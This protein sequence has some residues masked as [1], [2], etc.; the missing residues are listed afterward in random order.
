VSAERIA[1]IG[2]T[3]DLGYGLALRWAGAGVPVIIGSRDATRATDAAGR[4]N[5]ALAGAPPKFFAAQ[6]AANPDAA[7]QA[8]IVVGLRSAAEILKSI[9]GSLK[10]RLSFSPRCR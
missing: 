10:S 5:A 3:G 4:V 6:G 1:I 7:A 9:R 2:G 8:G